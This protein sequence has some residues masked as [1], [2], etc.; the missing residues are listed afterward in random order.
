MKKAYRKKSENSADDIQ[1]LISILYTSEK[2]L[3]ESGIV[4]SVNH[5]VLVCITIRT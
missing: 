1:R 2:K 5:A 4:I 3:S